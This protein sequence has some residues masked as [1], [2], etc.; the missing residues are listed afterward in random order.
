M[1]WSTDDNIVNQRSVDA[2]WK[3]VKSSKG[4]ELA[5]ITPNEF[6]VKS[7]GHFGLFRRKFKETL[8]PLVLNK[9]D[10]F[11]ETAKP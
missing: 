10:E 4:V 2:F 1:Y 8:W 5:K 3:H 7:I 6:G 11:H 9:L